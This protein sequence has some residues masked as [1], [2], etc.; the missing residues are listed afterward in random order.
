[1]PLSAQAR[2][3]RAAWLRLVLTPGIG[4]GAVRRLLEAFGLPEDVFAAGRTKLAAVLDVARAQAL[5][6]HDDAREAQIEASLRWAE[7][8]RHHL[9]TLADPRYPPRLLAIGDPPPLLFVRGNESETSRLGV[10]ATRKIGGAVR[11]NLAKRRIRE[12]FRTTAVPA[13]FDIV[14]V[15]KRE[16]FDATWTALQA[17]F[18]S[19]LGRQFGRSGAV[20]PHGRRS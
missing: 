11:R 17:D 20:R 1:M 16:F 19:A 12:M 13:G 9:L 6:A 2:D 15:P 8:E 14:V 10:A 18:S 5:V 3:E 7:D 4:P